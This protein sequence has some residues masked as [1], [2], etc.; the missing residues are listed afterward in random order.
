MAITLGTALTPERM[1]GEVR[2]TD[3]TAAR[4]GEQVTTRPPEP[5]LAEPVFQLPTVA[6]GAAQAYNPYTGAYAATRQ[7]SNAY[8]SWGQSVYSKNGETAYTQHA[9]NA[10]GSVRYRADLGWRQGCGQQHGVWHTA[11]PARRPSGDMY[12]AHDGNVYKNTGSGWQKYNNGSWNNVQKPSTTSAQSYAQ[13]H[14]A[15]D[16]GY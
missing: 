16:S 11:L 6:G 12:A 10:Y 9:S 3:R 2:P 7:G 1:D 8:G 4:I 13:Q 15:G 5:T 14:P